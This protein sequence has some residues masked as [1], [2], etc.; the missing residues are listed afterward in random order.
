MQFKHN[1]EQFI[2]INVYAPNKDSPDFFK[3]VFS[4]AEAM[5][6]HR[7]FAGDFN[8]VLDPEMDR[9]SN[10]TV[11]SNSKSAE[12]LKEYMSENSIIDVWRE[13]NPQSRYY[14]W[15]VRKDKASRLDM[16]LIENSALSWVRGVHIGAKFKSD[17]N[18]VV[19]EII[20]HV[21]CRGS[22]VWKLNTS[23]LSDP[24]FVEL[25]NAQIEKTKKLGT[26][27]KPEDL[28]ETLKCEL[29]LVC[30]QFSIS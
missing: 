22:G 17:H 21:T 29:I 27:L 3:N 8:L 18:K 25:I 19:L 15:T 11:K 5:E 6:G 9:K 16:F 7:I 13:R 24:E 20:P 4:L 28:W 23:H 2:L 10:V 26:S 30:K 1:E 12:F 14:T